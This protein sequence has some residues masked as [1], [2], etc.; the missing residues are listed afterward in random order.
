MNPRQ[1]DSI[2]PSVAPIPTIAGLDLPGM[3]TGDRLHRLLH[4]SLS[5][6]PSTAPLEVTA[7]AWDASF[8]GLE[9]VSLFR[10]SSQE[11][12]RAILTLANRDV[13]QEISRV[14]QAGVGYMAKMVLLAETTEE[15][16][17]YGLFTADETVHLSQISPFISTATDQVRALS[18]EDA[19]LQF[20]SNLLGSEDKS[21]LLLV[22]QIVLEGWGLSHY[23]SLAKNCRNP[24][25]A[26]VLTSFLQAEARHHA[27]GVT[28]LPA[29]LSDR[30]QAAMMEA[31]PPFLQ[32][33]QVGPQRLLTAIAQVKGS[34]SRAEK[35]RI[36]EEL[37]TETHSGQRL[38][39][40]R[41]LL[42]GEKTNEIGQRLE[43]LG[44]FQPFPAYRCV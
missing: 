34:L 39:L 25:L 1:S 23:R 7:P 21:L 43:D 36:L 14:E 38:Q 24:S 29:V 37:D 8:L 17:L 6:Y 40:L 2:A 20:L 44:C 5:A 35:I 19:F 32:M 10:Q 9:R 11:D 33:V 12:Q 15:R 26:A 42:R 28:L 4:A 16:M 13:L 41:S 3:E 27:A 18:A 22:I 30:S 31:L